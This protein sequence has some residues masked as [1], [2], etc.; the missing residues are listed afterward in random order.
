LAAVERGDVAELVR[1]AQTMRESAGKPTGTTASAGAAGR[2]L[3]LVGGNARY[4]G[5]ADLY[6]IGPAD[7]TTW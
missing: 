3:A 1:L 2:L 7:V 6:G 5:T 4:G